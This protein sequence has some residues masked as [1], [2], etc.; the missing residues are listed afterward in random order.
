MMLQSAFTK[1][2]PDQRVSRV[3]IRANKVLGWR[4]F[5]IASIK[6]RWYREATSRKR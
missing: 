4:T 5:S 6:I 1:G 3:F 2:G